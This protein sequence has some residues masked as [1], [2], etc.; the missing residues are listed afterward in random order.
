MSDAKEERKKSAKEMGVRV[1]ELRE[2]KE[3][4]QAKMYQ[5]FRSLTMS[6]LEERFGERLKLVLE[7]WDES[8]PHIHA[9]VVPVM[10]K[11]E[12]LRDI[13]PGLSAFDASEDKSQSARHKAYRTAMRALQDDFHQWVGLPLGWKRNKGVKRVSR[14]AILTRKWEE[15]NGKKKASEVHG[16][17][18]PYPCT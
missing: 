7:H 1:K 17:C 5:L 15:Q 14:A 8:H 11:C 12:S 4:T 2:K 10:N 9:Y 6:W 3:L 18:T 16:V 13:H